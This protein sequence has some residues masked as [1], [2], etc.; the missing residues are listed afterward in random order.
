[1]RTTRITILSLLGLLFVAYFALVGV[2]ISG[3]AILQNLT[4]QAP[5]YDRATAKVTVQMFNGTIEGIDPAGL[6]IIIQTEMGMQALP[7][8]S[9]EVIYG[10]AQGDQVTVKLDEQ[11]YVL[12]IVKNNFAPKPAPGPRS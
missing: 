8:A 5:I 11:G 7:V 2:A 12:A 4:D 6:R 1:M 9:E 10:L 3:V